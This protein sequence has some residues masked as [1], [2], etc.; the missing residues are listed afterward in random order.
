MRDVLLR[1][2]LTSV[3]AILVYVNDII[4]PI[5]WCSMS[6]SHYTQH[7]TSWLI[8][9]TS[10]A[11]LYDI[12]FLLCFYVCYL[13]FLG[14][15]V[16]LIN[17]DLIRQG[18]SL[19]LVALP[20][21]NLWCVCESNSNHEARSLPHCTKGRAPKPR[22]GGSSLIHPQICIYPILICQLYNRKQFLACT[23]SWKVIS[24]VCQRHLPPIS[25]NTRDAI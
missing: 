4:W 10:F 24:E 21:I 2:W 8:I 14:L 15:D 18:T 1:I 23:T 16:G 19:W 7:W 12:V 22:H 9:M 20:N 17:Y 13:Q 6:Q 3:G 25:F 5:L 11:P